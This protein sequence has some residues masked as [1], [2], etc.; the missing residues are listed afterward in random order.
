MLMRA[1]LYVHMLQVY[2]YK[3]KSNHQQ[4]VL[5]I[6]VSLCT[7][8][9]KHGSAPRSGITSHSMEKLG[10]RI[11]IQSVSGLWTKRQL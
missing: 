5:H 2:V 4:F 1:T 3:L 11:Q 6:L 10:T 8:Y 7:C 9:C